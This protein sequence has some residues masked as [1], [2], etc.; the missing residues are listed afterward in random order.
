MQ[1]NNNEG[2]NEIINEE[3][4]PI[5]DQN[6]INN[7]PPQNNENNENYKPENSSIP[8]INSEEE[9]KI[10][11]E[12]DIINKENKNIIN[13]NINNNNKENNIFLNFPL[14]KKNIKSYNFDNLSKEEKM[15]RIENILH[16]LLSEIS[17]LKEKGN[18]FYKNKNYEEAEKQYIEGIKKINES[19]LLPDIDE[20]NGQINNY[21]ISINGLNLQ[22]YNNLSAALIKQE[23]YE[24][25][26]K[27][28]KF[29]IEN[30]NEDHVVSYCRMLF[31]LIEIKKIILA[32]HYA[33][34]IKKK[35]GN[36]NSISKFQE[37]FA[38]LE[39]LNREFSEKILNQNP[40]LKKEIASM[41]EDLKVKNEDKKEENNIKKYIPYMIGGAFLLFAGGRYIYKK[42]KKND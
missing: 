2:E 27:N 39:V 38:K 32:N 10:K 24:E 9:N 14:I 1:E 28:C 16:S 13:N 37:Q 31:C 23:K 4:K 40:E 21:L 15:E 8:I 30:L 41:N 3:S 11:N 26:I 5:I 20:L 36:E 35:F 42:L 18:E 34:I 29:I 25:T 7:P 22:L 12:E 33:E 6:K 19:S 17:T